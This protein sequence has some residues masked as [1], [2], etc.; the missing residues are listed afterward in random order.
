MRCFGGTWV[1]LGGA[2]EVPWGV[3]GHSRGG[4]GGILG[5]PGD[6]SRVLWGVLEVPWGVLGGPGWPSGAPWESLG[7]PWGLLP[8]GSLTAELQARRRLMN[9]SQKATLLSLQNTCAFRF[10]AR[11]G[12]QAYA[13]AADLR[14]LLC[15]YGI[16]PSSD[17]GWGVQR[18]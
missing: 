8:N 2:L 10:A 1:T 16:I 18:S 17:P 11:P 15:Y 7:E 4:L 3:L 13:S 5:C 14:V 9:M 12:L 6:V